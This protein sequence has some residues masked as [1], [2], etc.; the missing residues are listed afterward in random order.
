[1]ADL[2][3]GDE[4]NGGTVSVVTVD[5]QPYFR[6]A[7]HDVI[8]AT[9]GFEAI[10][11]ACSGE[12]AL[13]VVRELRP[14]LVLVDVRMPD[15]DGIETTRRIKAAHPEVVVVLISIEDKA[16]V[17]AAAKTSGAAALVQKRD[18]G[19]SLLRGLWVAHGTAA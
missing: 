9:P 16:N 8:E 14:Q 17:P 18:F 4:S 2:R 13:G 12:E 15:M 5:D 1:M 6:G 3:P 7:A 19:P 10:G 11:E